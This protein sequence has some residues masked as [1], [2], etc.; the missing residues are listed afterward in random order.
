MRAMPARATLADEDRHPAGAAPPTSLTAT[1]AVAL[2]LLMGAVGGALDAL[3]SPGLG[4]PFALLF[5]GASL[6]VAARTRRQDLVTTAVLPP[7]AFGVAALA[8]AAVGPAPH[9]SA[10]GLAD[11]GWA[12]LATMGEAAPTLFTAT[13]LVLILAWRRRRHLDLGG[14]PRAA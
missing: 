3:L 2:S 12:T 14:T 5:V 8:A 6:W 13:A 7:L 4:V 1:G 10:D 11:Y 9:R